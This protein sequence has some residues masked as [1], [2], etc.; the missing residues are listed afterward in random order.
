MAAAVADLR[1]DADHAGAPYDIAVGLPLGTDPMPY[2]AAG[3][4]W[5]LPEVDPEAVSLDVVRG[6]IR[7]GPI[8]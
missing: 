3:A 6:L 5:W 1:R 7:D 4:T 2:A 8:S